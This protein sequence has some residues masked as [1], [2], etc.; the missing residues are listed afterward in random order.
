MDPGFYIHN[1]DPILVQLWGPIA[2]RWYG[3]SYVAGFVVGFLLLNRWSKEGWFRIPAEEVQ[4]LI[5]YAV[6]GVMLGGRLGFVLLYDFPQW[7]EDPLL[8]FRVW[9][10][11]MASHGGMIGLA[12]AVYL[13][14]RSRR[15]PFLHVMDALVC[16]GP[17]GIFFGRV[18]NF[19]NG[20]LWG[21][22]TAVRWAVI[23]PQEAGL[24]PPQPGLREEA[25]RLFEAG[26]L[27][28]RHPSQ[29]YAA[30]AEGLLVFG[31]MLWLRR[32]TW[33]AVD[34]RLSAIFLV[35]YAVGRIAVEFFR[36]PEIAYFGWLT[37]GQL[38]SLL[39][40]IPAVIV[41]KRV[42]CEK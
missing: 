17:I 10:G 22:V 13:F 25:L 12:L 24:Y 3:L 26:L 39:M 41:W 2:V 38:L 28:P 21:R 36:V 15:V 7:R 20:E 33:T 35:A 31:L 9:Q 19:I 34:G 1:I 23:F 11:G 8:L 5:F 37:Q 27:H 30:L 40:I 14:A 16:A 32:S 18:A 6:I 29:L 42:K 4:T